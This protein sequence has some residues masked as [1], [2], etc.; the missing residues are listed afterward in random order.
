MKKFTKLGVVL[1]CVFAA[2][3]ALA[4]CGSSSDSEKYTIATDTTFAPFEYE[5]E[6]GNFVGIDMDLL[7]AIADDQ[8]FEYEIQQVGFDAAVQS[9]EAG[10]CDGVIA[11]MSITDERKEKFDFSDPYFDSGVQMAVKSDNTDITSYEDLKGKNVAVKKGTEG[12]D[13]AD[14][15]KDKYGF[16]M[17]T[18]DDSSNMYED[19][20]SGNSVAC[21]EDY[22]VIAYAINQGQ[23]LKLV[24]DKQQGSS[25]GFAVKKGENAELLEKFNAGLKNLKENGKYQEI[26]DKYLSDSNS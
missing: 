17:T 22:P 12:Y 14:S 25:Y 3:L 7:A 16:T 26:L 24:G 2:V 20:K 8:G 15:I 18:F 13:Y 23:P 9:L 6:D 4:G 21:F 5:D 11:G 1:I 19:V 10:Q